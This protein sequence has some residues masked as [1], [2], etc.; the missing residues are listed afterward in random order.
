[1]FRMLYQGLDKEAFG[2]WS[3]L[4]SIFGYGILLDFGFGYT[5][6]K[7][8]A[9]L[10]VKQ[11]WEHLSQVLSTIVFVYLGSAI[12][13]IMG[14]W[15]FSRPM[16]QLFNVSAPNQ[17]IFRDILIWFFAGI[18]L[19]FPL[20]I[21]PEILRGQQ[22]IAAANNIA[23]GGMLA[24]F[25]LLAFALYYHWSLKAI[26]ILA[27]LCILVPDAIAAY[28][29]LKHMPGVRIGIRYF[30]QTMI[31]E[32][33]RF[34]VYAYLNMLSN[35]LRNKTDQLVIST[36][37]NV[38]A[39]TPYQAGGK[40]GEMYGMLTRQISDTLSPAAAHLHAKGD[41][42]TLR[43]LLIQGMRASV[44]AATPLYLICTFYLP[45]IIRLLTGEK[46]PSMDTIW[47]GH[48]LLFWYYC[49][50]VTHMVF[51]RMYMMCGHEKRMMQLG[52]A[53]AAI[54]VTLSIG[55]V[56]YFKNIVGVAVGSLIPTLYFG[57]FHLWPW[58]SREAQMKPSDLLRL[59]LLQ[60]WIGCLPMILVAAVLKSIPVLHSGSTVWHLMVEGAF[61]LGIGAM[62]IWKW[63]LSSKERQQ[64][65]EKFG[66]R[67]RR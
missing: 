66:K 10:S 49:I 25:V 14:A 52:V 34:S 51:K 21:F 8:V 55:L 44:I 7:R 42:Q 60:P 17:E 13:I 62:G 37:L 36:F 63:T 2:F 43:Q 23:M 12:V 11:E 54:N 53:E 18:A 28:I 5:A 57:W 41:L 61:G 22:R 46:Q 4:W 47:V 45:G 56:I 50:I 27:L 40:V 48:L 24:N 31:K 58:A 1:M 39:V 65:T 59:V 26:F 29:S 3:L 15:A 38:S 32:T 35:I 20:G 30:S 6:Q 64:F 9:E 19:G 67:F 16:I 33:T